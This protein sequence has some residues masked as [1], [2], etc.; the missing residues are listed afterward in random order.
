MRQR[1]VGIQLYNM[2]N[3][4][5]LGVNIIERIATNMA[6][7]LHH[8]VRLRVYLNTL[9]KPSSPNKS[10]QSCDRLPLPSPCSK[11]PATQGSNQIDANMPQQISKH[12]APANVPAPNCINDVRNQQKLKVMNI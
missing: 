3:G 12:S 9:L 8:I 10:G 7:K 2:R 5:Q 4:V 1:G 6:D 11:R